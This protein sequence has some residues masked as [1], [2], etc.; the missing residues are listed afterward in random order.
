MKPKKN[1]YEEFSDVKTVIHNRAYTVVIITDGYEEYK[2][3][4]RC[5]SG[6]KRDPEKG[7]WIAYAKAQRSKAN[8]YVI[9][10]TL[11]VKE[12]YRCLK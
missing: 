5:R 1:Y 12:S 2:G 7:F 3:V 4:T 10:T 11:L 6:T 9:K 8:A